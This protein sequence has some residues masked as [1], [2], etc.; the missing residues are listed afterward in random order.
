MSLNII[1]RTHREKKVTFLGDRRYNVQDVDKYKFF[2][3][4]NYDPVG[5]NLS[6]DGGAA[7]TN[8]A[9]TVAASKFTDLDSNRYDFMTIPASSDDELIAVA[10]MEGKTVCRLYYIKAGTCTVTLTGKDLEG[11]TATATIAI[12]VT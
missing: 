5:T 8:E 1:A 6:S 11:V 9:I 4:T 10:V 3:K 7:G 2:G 12:T